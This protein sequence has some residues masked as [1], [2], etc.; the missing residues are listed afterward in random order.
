MTRYFASKVFPFFLISCAGVAGLVLYSEDQWKGISQ[1]LPYFGLVLL[2]AILMFIT[3][4]EITRGGKLQYILLGVAKRTIEIDH[5]TRIF[6]CPAHNIFHGAYKS[7]CVVYLKD[8]KE[9][10]FKISLNIFS[11][12]ALNDLF[13]ELKSINPSISIPANTQTF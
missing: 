1:I 8:G 5:I 3:R 2:Y 11:K 7:L 9:G 12:E 6:K 13:K 10:T 4:I